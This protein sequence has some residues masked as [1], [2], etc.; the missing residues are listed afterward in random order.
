MKFVKLWFPV[1]LWCGLIFFL[2]HQPD[3]KSDLPETWDFF[4]RK[5][6][7]MAEFG[8]LAVLFFKGLRGHNFKVSRGLIF[9]LIFSLLYAASDEYHQTFIGGR[10]GSP[11]D[12]GI[13]SI[14]IIIAVLTI[15]YFY[16]KISESGKGMAPSSSG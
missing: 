6:A 10:S 11:I 4:L 1:V 9:T 13:D 16:A 14:G 7:H 2:S 3:L 15:W 5:L 12:M 8:L